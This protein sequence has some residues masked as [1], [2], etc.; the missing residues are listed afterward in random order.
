VAQNSSNPAVSLQDEE[1]T[2][3]AVDFAARLE[4]STPTEALLLR[5][6]LA[7]IQNLTAV[8]VAALGR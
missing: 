7:E 2:A 3:L 5:A 1:Q 8:L 6:I 4:V